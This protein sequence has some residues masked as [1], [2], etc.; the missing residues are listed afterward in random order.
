VVFAVAV[1]LAAWGGLGLTLLLLGRRGATDTPG[2]GELLCLSVLLGLATVSFVLFLAGLIHPPAAIGAATLTC[3]GLGAWGVFWHHPTLTAIVVRRRGWQDW[4]W[5]LVAL[6]IIGGTTAVVWWFSQHGTLRFDGVAVWEIKARL[7]SVHHGTIPSGYYRDPTRAWS[8]PLYPPFIPL[9]EGW[10]YRWVGHPDQQAALLL[11]PLFF[12][13]GAGL[14]WAGGRR[15]TGRRLP[16]AV[17]PLLLLAVPL[18]T[19]GDGSASSGY[20]DVPIAVYYLAAV[21]FVLDHLLHDRASSLRIA[22]AIAMVLPWVKQEGLV[23]FGGLA[24]VLVGACM[25]RERRG[26]LRP[27]AAGLAIASFC[28][29]GLFVGVGWRVYLS[30]VHAIREHDYLPYTWHTLSS[31]IGRL[32]MIG[33]HLFDELA[34][35]DRWTLLWPW[36]GATA[37]L[38][39][40]ARR[41]SALQAAPLLVILPAAADCGVYLFSA[42][43]PVE[44]H[45]D[46]SLSRLLL[47]LTPVAMLLIAMSLPSGRRTIRPDLRRSRRPA[48][49]DSPAER[50][51]D[52]F[53]DDTALDV[54]ALSDESVPS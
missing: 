38:W 23:L 46:S 20:A 36:F 5:L 29:P 52:A 4:V 27:R 14:L 9:I 48:H 28:L 6:V 15:L 40:V 39:F 19:D 21:I 11:F 3:A 18:I 1:L 13:I 8:H 43:Q 2:A 31:N 44:A 22:A 33:S 45:I 42:W 24:I 10:V 35:W 47:Q 30:H 49:D 7:A 26:A 32:P 53:L 37:V 51:D 16:A 41:G 54:T 12:A 25:L 17:G 34:M 50:A